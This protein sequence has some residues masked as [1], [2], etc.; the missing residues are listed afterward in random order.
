MTEKGPGW[1]SRDLCLLDG[2]GSEIPIKQ[3]IL[4]DELCI[5]W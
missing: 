2:T 5:S 3:L 4:N 1:S